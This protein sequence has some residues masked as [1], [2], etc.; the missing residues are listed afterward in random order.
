MK[1]NRSD[2]GLWAPACVQHGFSDS[3][4]FTSHNYLV[5]GVKLADAVQQ[6]INDPTHALWLQD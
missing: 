2:V 5:K 4:A 3:P 6:F 1:S